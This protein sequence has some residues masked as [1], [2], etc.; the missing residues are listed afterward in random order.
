[1]TRIKVCGITNLRDA[2]F[3][4]ELGADALGFVFCE[5]SP[6]FVTFGEAR[7]IIDG[8]PPFV[9]GVGVFVNAGM[10]FLARA[11]REAGFDVYQLHGDETPEFCSGLGERYIKAVRVRGPESLSA[12][13]LYD[14]DCFLFDGWSP[15]AYGGT[16]KG[17]S[18]ETLDSD[19]LSGRFVILSGGL[20]CENV[21][22]AVREVRPHAV[23]VS[24]GVE[25][26]PGVKDHSKLRRFMEAARNGENPR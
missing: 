22:R 16:G 26:S 13:G 19:V 7:N 20:D 10:D 17:F 23:D 15:D 18:W 14:T 5:E 21:S 25:A 2:L 24:S 4:A 8:L 12:V 3:A 9:T 1:M 6:R 11:K